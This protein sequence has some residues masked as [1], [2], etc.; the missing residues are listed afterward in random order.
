M[1]MVNVDILES[2]VVMASNKPQLVDGR[3]AMR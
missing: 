2:E 1:S 3:T